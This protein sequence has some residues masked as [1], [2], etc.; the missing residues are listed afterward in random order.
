MKQNHHA[1]IL[2]LNW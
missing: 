1:C 2:V